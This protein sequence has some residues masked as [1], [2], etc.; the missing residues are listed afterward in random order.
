[1]PLF[2][3]FLS[4]FREPSGEKSVARPLGRFHPCRRP[5]R[6]RSRH[7]NPKPPAGPLS[8]GSCRPSP[9]KSR[10]GRR[11]RVISQ[12]IPV[13]QWAPRPIFRRADICRKP[14][15]G[16]IQVRP[17]IPLHAFVPMACPFLEYDNADMLLAP[18]SASDVP[19][20]VVDG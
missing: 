17:L 12:Q 6:E 5:G 4:T 13:A 14:H 8:F 20:P 11:C 1:M 7:E 18:F 15:P 10:S 9:T 19:K 16:I 3:T 2:L